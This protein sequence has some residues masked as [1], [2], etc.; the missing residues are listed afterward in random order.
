MFNAFNNWTIYLFRWWTNLVQFMLL[1]VLEKMI[2]DFVM[3]GMLAGKIKVNFKLIIKK[4][5][6][7]YLFM[8]QALK[9]NKKHYGGFSDY[10][11]SWNNC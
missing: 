3:F 8:V 10:R 2:A 6:K 11:S 1:K 4:W 9:F 7:I 5:L